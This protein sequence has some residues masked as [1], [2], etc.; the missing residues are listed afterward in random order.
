MSETQSSS[1]SNGINFIL[2]ILG[3]VVLANT[4]LDTWALLDHKSYIDFIIFTI[5]ASFAIIVLACFGGCVSVALNNPDCMN[6]FMISIPI[7]FILTA[8][9]LMG[10]IWHID[11]EHS[12]LFYKGFWTEWAFDVPKGTSGVVFYKIGDV[13]IRIYS[14]SII[15]LTL[16]MPCIIPPYIVLIRAA[17]TPSPMNGDFQASNFDG[18][19]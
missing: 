15:T 19:L 12:V 1:S 4:S 13:M 18:V 6:C 14:V 9:S 11:P 10:I 2:L 3:I 16:C 7:I 5:S 17:S 8:Y